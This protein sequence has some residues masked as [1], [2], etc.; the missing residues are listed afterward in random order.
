MDRHDQVAIALGQLQARQL[1][2]AVPAD[3]ADDDLTRRIA[4]PHHANGLGQQTVPFC[5]G[6]LVAGLVEK[7]E[8]QG[9]RKSW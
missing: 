1:A 2:D 8:C 5:G 9:G 6:Q 3:R 4:L 7:L